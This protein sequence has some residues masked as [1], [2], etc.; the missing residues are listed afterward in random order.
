MYKNF[1][2]IEIYSVVSQAAEVDAPA[3]VVDVGVVPVGSVPALVVDEN[4]CVVPV[5]LPSTVDRVG[6]VPAVVVDVPQPFN[7]SLISSSTRNILLSNLCEILEQFGGCGSGVEVVVI[8]IGGLP[9]GG[10]PI[11]G[12]PISGLPNGGRKISD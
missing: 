1:N 8:Q 4:V 12:L 3:V 6:S 11:G 9:I 2:D 5:G 7:A 10:L